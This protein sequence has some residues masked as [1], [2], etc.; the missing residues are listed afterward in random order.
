M[1][2]RSPEI[3]QRSTRASAT[4]SPYV[5]FRRARLPVAELAALGLDRY[6]ARV[7]GWR[8]RAAAGARVAA[9]V[10][11]RLAALVPG[12]DQTV[13]AEIVRLR[14]DVYNGRS[15]PARRRLT[16][17]EPHLGAAA[18]QV[19]AWLELADEVRRE[20]RDLRT[21]FDAELAAARAGIRALFEHDAMAKGIQL[22]GDQLYESLQRYVRDDGPALKPSR[23]RTAES[24]LVNFAYRAA[25][26]PSP[27]G[28]FTEV[29]A[30][31]P[32]LP[33]EAGGAPGTQS[34][35]T[36]NRVLLNWMVGG[37]QRLP[38]GDDLGRMLLNSS[39]SID[40]KSI[41]FIGLRP[42]GRATGYGGT[43]QVVRLRRDPVVDRVLGVLAGGSAPVPQL[44][45]AL[46]EVAGGDEAARKVLRALLRTG[47]LSFR[48]GIDEQDPAYAAKLAD[49]LNSAPAGPLSVLAADLRTLRR[50][51][52]D[53][54]DASVAGRRALLAVGN[55]AIAEV[56]AVC[57]VGAPPEAI[58]RA[59]VYEDAWTRARPATWN[60][61]AIA[62]AR[63]ALASL[64]RFAS[65]LDYGQVKRLGL[66]SFA[67]DRFGDRETVPFLDFFDQL[68]RLPEAEQDAV[69]AGHGSALARAYARRRDAAL[70]EL[71]DRIVPDGDGVLRLS[72]EAVD[73]ACARVEDRV[74]PAS[75]TFR[76]QF[77]RRA[78]RQPAVVVNG[79]LTGY[80]VYF[81]RFC[82][83]IDG[84]AMPGW[85][86]RSA[87]RDHLRDAFGGQVDL[88][89]VLGFN[90]NLHPPL[91]DRV[92]DYP[93]S[94]P[95][96]TA[97]RR[98]G[99]GDLAIRVDH[100]SHR[101][102]LWDPAAGAPLDLM[103]MNFLIPVGVPVL[104][105]LLEAL[106]PTTRYPWHPLDDIRRV[107]DPGGAGRLVVGD[108]VADRR[109]WTVPARDI[110]MLAEV[111][112]DSYPAL[113]RFD[114]WRRSR[115]L[116]RDAFVLCQTPDEY[117]VLS[118]RTRGLPRSWS[119]FEHLHRASVHK[120]M[121]VDFRNP[122]SVR[123][124]AKSAL[125]RDD[126]HLSIRECLPA[127]DE[128]GRGD[129]PAAA[130]E[131]F[132]ELYRD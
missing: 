22:S 125:T 42:D 32:D 119:D 110:P 84:S 98:Y 25:L 51:E 104:Y 12:A 81:S 124:L 103:P 33:P 100:G 21:L 80:G 44:R 59:P 85:T 126:V 132:V 96:A 58:V 46:A 53:F 16:L 79:V 41:R 2:V 57:G 50:L 10:A 40:E 54:P 122:L 112:R 127:T 26:K 71:G 23:L 73:D 128:Y 62:A 82:R 131:F 87:L 105:Q 47:L 15:D 97:Q 69:F 45:Q 115:G 91:T 118:G 111:S 27:F 129:G 65:M 35:T 94:W 75:I 37:W 77:A 113:L 78:D 116:P 11:D 39:L 9:E 102:L 109:S 30:F 114:E 120:P 56:G 89:A 123:S 74:D 34:S 90:F 4:L 92:L 83:F 93:G 52:T 70:H 121:Y 14:R 3:L 48:P 49:L 76:V 101:L 36:L 5:V 8:R 64:W 117:A 6:W 95:S 99:L 17:T 1:T 18:G 61:D 108:V 20:E 7:D 24:S 86:L 67:V 31:P 68:V 19:R 55:R 72:P 63:P 43:E 29:G 130:E 88:N 107:R 38:G 106:S 28:R 66:Y 13:R 60:A